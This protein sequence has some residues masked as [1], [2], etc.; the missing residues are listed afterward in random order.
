MASAVPLFN[1]LKHLPCPK[2]TE[3]RTCTTTGCLF[4][5]RAD[6][7]P[8]DTRSLHRSFDGA[9]DEEE[10]GPASDGNGLPPSKRQKTAI[11]RPG[12]VEGQGGRVGDGPASGSHITSH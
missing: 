2:E 12:E 6:S 5:H 3:G 1:G 8:S 9:A 7:Q 4:G 11:H 10:E